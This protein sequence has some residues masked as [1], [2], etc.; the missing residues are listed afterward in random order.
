[1]WDFEKCMK[2]KKKMLLV[3]SFS[4]NPVRWAP[5]VPSPKST[6]LYVIFGLLSD[7]YTNSYSIDLCVN[8]PLD[9]YSLV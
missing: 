4:Q 1:M 7:I 8:F 6:N 3:P 2:L 5:K 9:L